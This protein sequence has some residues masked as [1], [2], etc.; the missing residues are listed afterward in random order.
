[1]TLPEAWSLA[2]LAVHRGLWPADKLRGGC[3]CPSWV[4]SGR[5]VEV[6]GDAGA[7]GGAV[8]ALGAVAGGVEFVVVEGHGGAPVGGAGAAAGGGGGGAFGAGAFGGAFVPPGVVQVGDRVAQVR[9][10]D[11]GVAADEALDGFF[12]DTE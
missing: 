1:M 6:G 9:A 5:R 4:K 11:G 3:R 10:D 12:A 2:C 7:D 8:A